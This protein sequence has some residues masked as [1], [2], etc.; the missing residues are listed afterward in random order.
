VCVACRPCCG[1]TICRGTARLHSCCPDDATIDGDDIMLCLKSLDAQIHTS[2]MLECSCKMGSTLEYRFELVP[3]VAPAV[4]QPCMCQPRSWQSSVETLAM[5]FHLL[6]GSRCPAGGW[7]WQPPSDNR[8]PSHG[9]T[10]QFPNVSGFR[11][12]V[13]CKRSSI[14]G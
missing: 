12:A 3:P 7:F 14:T 9:L 13:F 8:L 6:C 2:F 5:T 1:H 11:A 4:A 10:K